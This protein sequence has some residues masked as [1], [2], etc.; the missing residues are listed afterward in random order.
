MA[1]DWILKKLTVSGVERA[2]RR[3]AEHCCKESTT[4]LLNA[5]EE[6]EVPDVRY[7]V[8]LLS[9]TARNLRAM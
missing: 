9:K 2:T 4:V 1:G 8:V 7:H 3:W 5:A 6:A